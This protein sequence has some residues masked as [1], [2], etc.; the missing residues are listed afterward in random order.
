[1]FPTSFW[2]IIT[3][4]KS[5]IDD[6]PPIYRRCFYLAVKLRKIF[7]RYLCL[8]RWRR[9]TLL[10]APTA[11]GR[12]HLLKY[13]VHPWY[14]KP[15]LKK[16]WGFSAWMLWYQGGALPGDEGIKYFPEGFLSR[17]LG[18]SALIGKGLDEMDEN[19][20]FLMQS[21]RAG[22]PFALV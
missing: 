4:N 14:V 1:M 22:C 20:Q 2:R 12:L 7:L 18:P 11:S 19:R 16:R 8:P 17:E 9:L 21:G 10:P 3:T 13:R 15:S 6:P 5:R